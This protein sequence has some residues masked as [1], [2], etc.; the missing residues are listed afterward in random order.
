[1]LEMP[2]QNF[3]NIFKVCF[4][5]YFIG[6]HRYAFTF[7]KDHQ[8]AKDVVQN[9]FIKWW[10]TKTLPSDLKSCK[11]YLY[12][13]VYRTSLNIIRNEKAKAVHTGIYASQLGPNSPGYL[14]LS[15]I[16][17][18]ESQTSQAIESLPQQSKM[19]FMKSR[20]EL[21]SNKTIA[22]EMNL[23]VKTVEGH[24]SKAIKIIRKRLKDYL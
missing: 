18:L 22:E 7:V 13:A 3:E 9:I 5:A 20:M 2:P 15:N 1:M 11:S 12:T 19:V 6:L 17:E 14:E 21:K 10:E 23:S 4:D 24:M 8:K 16:E